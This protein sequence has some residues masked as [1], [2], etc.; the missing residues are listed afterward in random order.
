MGEGGF[1]TMKISACVMVKNEEKNLPR[2]IQS[3]Q[4]LADE[5]IVVDTGST[6]RTIEI[7]QEAGAKV[8]H[9]PWQNDFATPKNY[10]IDQAQGDWIIFLDADEYFLPASKEKVLEVLQEIEAKNPRIN[11]IICKLI[12]VDADNHYRIQGGIH[13]LRIFKRSP[14]MRYHGKIHERLIDEDADMHEVYAT[15]DIVIY[16]T[17]YS[18]SIVKKKLE[19]NL[20]FLKQREKE[21][22]GKENLSD[23]LHYMDCYYALK[24]YKKAEHYARL[25]IDRH[26]YAQ[27]RAGAEY[28]TLYTIY[29]INKK[30][31]QERQKLLDEAMKTY[32]DEPDFPIYRGLL[33]WKKREY[34]ET[35][36]WL[37]KGIDLSKDRKSIGADGAIR[38]VPLAMQFLARI[39]EMRGHKKQAQEIYLESLHRNPY[40]GETLRGYVRTLGDIPVEDLIAR[41]NSMYDKNT[42]ADFLIEELRKLP[43]SPVLAY[44]AHRLPKN[45]SI[46]AAAAYMGA[47]RFDSASMLLSA[48]MDAFEQIHVE[49]Q[50]AQKKGPKDDSTAIIFPNVLAQSWHA[51]SLPR[52]SILIPTYNRPAYFEQTLQSALRQD[53]PNLEIIVTDN[54]TNDQ[55]EQCVEKYLGDHRL[56]YV[57]NAEAKTKADNFRPMEKLAT[58]E[59]IQWCMD[60]DILLDGKITLMMKALLA[61]SSI[62]LATSR[63]GFID[64]QGKPLPDQCADVPN[65]GKEYSIWDGERAARVTLLEIYNFL[66]EPSA[67]LY[68]RQ[69]LDF[70]YWNAEADGYLTISD[71][72]MQL[73]LLEKGDCIYFQHPLSCTRQHAKQEG[74]QEDVVLLSRQEWL[75]LLLSYWER[76]VFLHSLEDLQQPLK[77]LYSEYHKN[78]LAGRRIG[79]PK[80]WEAYA[81]DMEW[82]SKL[83]EEMA[84]EGEGTH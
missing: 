54:S 56:T 22:G 68:R 15:D 12:N 26:F 55:T 35:I 44:Y 29:T 51:R 69:D 21:N 7:A 58:G 19:R 73:N 46:N 11:A 49:A 53:W 47:G 4:G 45:E 76:K 2:W 74:R 43:P 66:G 84:H 52:V 57:R 83:L 48:G 64:E 37:Q 82:A 34:L 10:A 31:V 30:S 9:M 70:P 5:M 40:D 28:E 39:E 36:H 23:A 18:T 77:I 79:S 59:Y 38:A 67:F 72:R 1:G 62:K 50:L 24:D 78:I 65:N 14:K 13:Q 41:L 8:F 20:Q 75:R 16:H 42:D 25:V 63:R 3:M 81:K 33:C 60:D 27:G 71:V 17:G 61:D 80:A 6:D 32:P